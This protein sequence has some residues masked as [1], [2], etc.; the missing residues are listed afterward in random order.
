MVVVKLY[1]LHLQKIK[2]TK[3]NSDISSDKFGIIQDASTIN[4]Y[5]RP[6]ISFRMSI[7]GDSL[8]FLDR[9]F[10]EKLPSISHNAFFQW[11]IFECGH[12]R[13]WIIS[14]ETFHN[15]DF[16]CLCR[17]QW[18][19]SGTDNKM[20]YVIRILPIVFI[21]FQVFTSRIQSWKFR[22]Y[23][24]QFCIIRCRILR[25]ITLIKTRSIHLSL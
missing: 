21:H 17:D 18:F 5:K 25:S 7:F 15:R 20:C 14:A 9:D 3:P 10:Q 19:P 11:D 16:S 4:F 2:K 1:V 12:V 22:L 6:I 23:S 24:Y 13:R 8:R